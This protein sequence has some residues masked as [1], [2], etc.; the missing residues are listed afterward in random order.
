MEATRAICSGVPPN[1][2]RFSRCAAVTRFHGRAGVDWNLRSD[3]SAMRLAL[4]PLPATTL[5][6]EGRFSAYAYVRPLPRQRLSIDREMDAACV[7]R[8]KCSHRVLPGVS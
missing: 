4:S 1:P 7:L 8:L 6:A 2:A 3:P 5:E